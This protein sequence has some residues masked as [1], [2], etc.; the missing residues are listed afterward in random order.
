MHGAESVPVKKSFLYCLVV[1]VAIAAIVGIAAILSGDFGWFELRILLTTLTVAAASMCGLSSWVYRAARGATVLPLSGLVLTALASVLIV[2]G[3]WVEVDS[4]GYWKAAATF[5]V[6][7]VACAHLAL[8]SLARLARSFRWSL[9]AAHVIILAVATLISILILGEIE[10]EGMFRLLAVGAIVDAA[11]TL[12]VPIFHRLSRGTIDIGGAA[13]SGG[14]PAARRAAIDAEI[15]RLRARI[16]E[17][18]RS[19]EEL[20]GGRSA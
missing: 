19:R 8:L 9:V 17:L 6:F 12:L 4:E 16:E 20:A 7:A 15:A 5:S 14:E 18:E 1:S 3:L 11:I 10:E 2:A 13:V